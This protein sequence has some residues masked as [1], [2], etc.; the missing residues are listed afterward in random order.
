MKPPT[1]TAVS[2]GR[3]KPRNTAASP[4]TSSPTVR[5]TTA[6]D[7]LLELVDEER[8]EH[9]PAIFTEDLAVP[10]E[11]DAAAPRYVWHREGRAAPERTAARSP[12]RAVERP[13][14]PDP[15]RR[16]RALPL[17]MP[18]RGWLLV[19]WSLLPVRAFLAFTFLYAG[20]Q[21]LMNPAVLELGVPVLAAPADDRVHP[22]VADPPAPRPPPA[23]LDRRSACSWPLAE[24]A[25]GLGIGLG[26]WTRV[27][28][29]GGMVIS[30]QPL[31]G[32]ELPLPPVVHG[33]GHRLLLHVHALRHRRRR[34]RAQPRRAHRASRRRR[35]A[36]STTSASV[37]LPFAEAQRSCGNYDKGRC[38]AIPNRHCAPNG[39]PFLEGSRGR[40]CPAGA[41]P[42]H[43]DRRAVVLGRRRRG[44]RRGGGPRRWPAPWP[45]RAALVGREGRR[46]RPR[47]RCRR[48]P[49]PAAP[50]APTARPSARRPTCRSGSP[51]RSPCP[52]SGDPGLVI[53]P[54]QGQ[55][56]AY[57]AVCPHAACTVGYFASQQRHRVPVPRLGVR[58]LHRR[59]HRRTGDGGPDRAHGHRGGR[60]DLRQVARLTRQLR[61]PRRP[62]ADRLEE[63]ASPPHPGEH[64]G[65]AARPR[66]HPRVPAGH[67]V[68]VHARDLGE[69]DRR[70][71]GDEP[72]EA[73]PLGE[74]AG[75]PRCARGGR[76]RTGRGA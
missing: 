1:I 42:D 2:P 72:V 35:G 8:Q 29:V 70:R 61:A 5:Y 24:I 22:H 48:A 50:R 63:R 21:K 60:P 44:R 33:R 26:L 34:R 66:E 7:D 31:P 10:G 14:S 20:F 19:G 54:S 28:A 13:T 43:V 58:R 55:F 57:D 3:T 9:R 76:R 40:R 18:P 45:A 32:G 73:A 39:C 17:G 46:R 4:N 16:A 11:R 27:A 6:G 38:T 56:V 67:P 52:S 64:V 69:L 71:R 25:V 62:R 12:S 15:G 74:H 65:L 51:R 49:G 23:V 75:S 41:A 68:H 30:L 36:G 59:R 53:Q 37:V 47:G